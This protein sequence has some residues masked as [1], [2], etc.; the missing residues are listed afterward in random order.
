M[1]TEESCTI[2]LKNGSGFD[3]YFVPACHWQES[4]ASNVLKSGMQ[5]ADGLTVYIF[6]KDIDAALSDALQTRRN[7]AED[8]IVPGEC[9]FTFDSSTPQA[10]SQ[11]LKTLNSQYDVHTVMSLDRLLYGSKAL[12]HF[13][14]S[15]R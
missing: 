1:L 7:A 2:Y 10:A 12:R 3:R 13:K 4:K 8:L 15:A 11:S 14:L 5:N 6:V 9:N